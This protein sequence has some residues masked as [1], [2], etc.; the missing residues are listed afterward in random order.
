VPSIIITLTA[1]TP[2]EHIIAI[3]LTTLSS[4]CFALILGWAIV[5]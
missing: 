4:L 2:S 3:R 1:K 5:F